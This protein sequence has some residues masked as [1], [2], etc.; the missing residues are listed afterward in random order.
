ML[1]R[2]EF[3]ALSLGDVIEADPIFGRLDPDVATV[4]QVV[5][6]EV[7]ELDFLITYQGVYIGKVLAV[8]K[9]RAI[10]WEFY[11]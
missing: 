5:E 6:V 11:G 10:Q 1:T 9:D 4:F 3:E 7:N 8:L 2:E